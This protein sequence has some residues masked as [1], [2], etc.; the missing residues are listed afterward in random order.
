MTFVGLTFIALGTGGIKP[1]VSAFGGDQFQPEQQKEL[2]Q[3]FSLFYISING[4]SLIS[5]FITPILRQDVACMGRPDCYPLAFGVPAVLMIGMLT[6]INVILLL[7][8]LFNVVA[9]GLFI[10]GR[11]ATNYVMVPPQKDNVVIM[12]VKCVCHALGRKIFSKGN[13]KEHWLDY[14]DDQYDVSVLVKFLQIVK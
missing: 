2:K 10:L 9:L 12:V 13:K 4:G 8:L 11:F 14:S 3:F 1:C 6:K 7:I 5:T